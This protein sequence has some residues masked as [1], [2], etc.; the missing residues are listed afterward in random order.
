MLYEVITRLLGSEIR[1]TTTRDYGETAKHKADD[2]MFHLLLAT[3]S[4]ITLIAL[5]L[6][7]RE[8]VV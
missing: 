8:A 2:L 5:A 6:G 1:V 7:R 4:V 3:L